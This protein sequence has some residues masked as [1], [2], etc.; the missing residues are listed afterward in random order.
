MEIHITRRIVGIAAVLLCAAGIVGTAVFTKRVDALAPPGPLTW[1]AGPLGLVMELHDSRGPTGWVVDLHP[2]SAEHP[3]E[4]AH[5]GTGA[6]L[7]CPELLVCQ[8]GAQ[9]AL[10]GQ[11]LMFTRTEKP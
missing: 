1:K 4:V 6:R 7:G 8:A 10:R 5:L 9:N 11:P 3:Y 2:K